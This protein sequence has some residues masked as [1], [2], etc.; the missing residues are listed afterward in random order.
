MSRNPFGDQPGYLLRHASNAN[1]NAIYERLRPLDLRLAEASVLL[2]IQ[3]NPGVT[4][5]EACQTLGIA[6]ANMAPLVSRLD[7]K[8]LV[9]RKPVDGRSYGLTVT[10]Q[11]EDIANRA[12]AELKAHEKELLSA[13]PKELRKP[14][15]E[16]LAYVAALNAAEQTE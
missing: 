8:G 6:R 1:L 16:A 13:V 10:S 15:V 11:G 9:S 12:D 5:S 3:A 2:L 7:S 4:Q 14:F